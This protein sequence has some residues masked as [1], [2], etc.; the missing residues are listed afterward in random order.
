MIF[1]PRQ[2][3]D[4]PEDEH[5]P[6]VPKK[7]DAIMVG[8]V[9]L[10]VLL[11]VGIVSTYLLVGNRD[12]LLTWANILG[13][14]A[15]IMSCIQYLPQLWTTYKIGHVLSLSI[16]SMAIQVPGSFLFAF[17]LWL[18]VGWEGWST[19]LLYCLTG[20]L[21]GSL[22]GMAVYFSRKDRKSKASGLEPLSDDPSENDPL[23]PGR[24]NGHA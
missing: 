1:F 6:D 4:Q 21:Q 8:L 18:R 14:C 22:L 17:S 23:L 24:S 7:G 11:L 10:L 5:S 15:A 12:Y 9:S 19:W 20:V 3:L 2:G 13:I 16:T